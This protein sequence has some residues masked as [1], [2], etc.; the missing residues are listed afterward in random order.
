MSELN[1]AQK[2]P[3]W[4]KMLVIGALL[5]FMGIVVAYITGII[6]ERS[7]YKQTAVEIISDGWGGS[8]LIRGPVLLVPV[9]TTVKQSNGKNMTYE[10]LINIAPV[11]VSITGKITP[12]IRYKGI[13]KQPVYTTNLQIKGTFSGLNAYIQSLG[14]NPANVKWNKANIVTGISDLKGIAK[15]ITVKW[16]N[17]SKETF[18]GTCG[19][20]SF[21][22]GVCTPVDKIGSVNNFDISLTIK[23]SQFLKFL[24]LAKDTLLGLSSSWNNP[25]FIGNF[26][27]IEKQVTKDGFNAKWNISYLSTNIPKSWMDTS[28]SDLA[29]NT[30]NTDYSSGETPSSEIEKSFNSNRYGVELLVPVD[31][32]RNTLRAVKY[33]MLFVI[34]TFLVCF[35]F[36]V[37]GNYK[38]H[39][40]QYTLVGLSMLIFYL[41]L[42]SFSEF[43]NFGL[44]YIISGIAT[45]LLITAYTHFVLVKTEKPMFTLTMSGIL[46]SIYIYL[47]LLLQLQDLSLL[48]GSIGIFILIAATMYATRNVSW[49]KE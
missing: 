8:Q 11:N 42:L 28:I 46:V 18:P 32:Y 16:N 21:N 3:F 43:I 39:P 34:I 4:K 45:I 12:D 26:L 7:N 9:E 31:N 33:G 19:Q 49:Y 6:Q 40:F 13:F 15:N 29:D 24:P 47:Y 27:P 1:T 22:K 20:K 17:K 41:L 10:E 2:D 23:G 5:L 14:V 35:L 36:E 25:S 44:A 30:Y 37:I 48:F 38:I